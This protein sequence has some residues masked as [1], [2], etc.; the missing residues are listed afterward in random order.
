MG[1]E[2]VLKMGVKDMDI[3]FI[4]FLVVIHVYFYMYQLFN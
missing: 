1:R 4:I 2:W 3:S